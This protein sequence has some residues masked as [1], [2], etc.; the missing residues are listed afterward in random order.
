MS[1]TKLKHLK[2]FDAVNI[3]LYSDL[4]WQQN[5]VKCN[6]AIYIEKKPNK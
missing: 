2:R 4:F 3:L 1:N 5:G 6:L